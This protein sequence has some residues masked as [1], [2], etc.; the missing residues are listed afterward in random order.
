MPGRSLAGW[1]V[2][3]RHGSPALRFAPPISV[4]CIRRRRPRANGFFARTASGEVRYA[5]SSSLASDRIEGKFFLAIRALGRLP[6]GHDQHPMAG[7]AG[8][9]QRFFPGSEITGRIVRAGVERAPFAGFAFDQFAAVLRALYAGFFQPGFH[10]AA[11]RECGTPDEFSKPAVADHQ[12]IPARGAIPPE[13]FRGVADFGDFFLGVP[14]I[15]AE[16][17][18]KLLQGGSPIMRALRRS[19]PVPLPSWP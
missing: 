3:G 1:T 8:D 14:E 11:G 4:D 16:R 13:Q 17:F 6:V 5:G 19:R 2:H 12:R 7:R 18:V 10:V 15:F 9:G